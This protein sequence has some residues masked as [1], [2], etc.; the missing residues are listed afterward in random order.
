MLQ[1][2]SFFTLIVSFEK[3]HYKTKNADIAHFLTDKMQL[4]IE[5]NG[6]S[7]LFS[8]NKRYYYVKIKSIMKLG[9]FYAKNQIDGQM[10]FILL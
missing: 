3:M 7:A 8:V 5:Y 1:N 2:V 6:L 4:S 9:V 10:P